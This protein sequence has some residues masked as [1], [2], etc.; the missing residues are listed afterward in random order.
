[1]LKSRAARS[2][3][4]PAWPQSPMRATYLIFLFWRIADVAV[5]HSYPP[6]R[7]AWR[8]VTSSGLAS[9]SPTR[10]RIS[11]TRRGRHLLGVLVLVRRGA[12][13]R[14]APGRGAAGVREG[15]HLRQPR[16]PVCRADQPRRTA[17]RELPSGA[18]PPGADQ[19]RVQP[20][21]CPR[22]VNR[23]DLV[24]TDHPPG[25][26]ARFVAKGSHGHEG[27]PGNTRRS[28]PPGEPG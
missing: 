26:E 4:G 24:M 3:I 7:M 15:A 19:R 10:A 6:A 18:D 13:P 16:G 27:A 8:R 23:Q 21:P 28:G 22:R 12:R 5:M 9:S 20:R 25:G 14:R 11:P 1:M 17:A 2:G